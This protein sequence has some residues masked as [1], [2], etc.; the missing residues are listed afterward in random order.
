MNQIIERHKVEITALCEEFGVDRLEVFG[1]A[2]TSEFDPLR[3]DI[4]FLVTY[5]PE[6]DIGPWMQRFFE[7]RDRLSILLG[8][9]IDLLESKKFRNPFFEKAVSESRISIYEREIEKAA[10]GHQDRG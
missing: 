3:S 10:V 8:R 5:P 4:D 2:N 7:L 6:Y 9:P 1:S